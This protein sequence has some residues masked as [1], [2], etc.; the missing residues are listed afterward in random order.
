MRH[1]LRYGL[2]F[3]FYILTHLALYAFSVDSAGTIYAA[4]GAQ[5]TS[6]MYSLLNGDGLLD[7]NRDPYS[8]GTPLYPILLALL[9]IISYGNFDLYY[10]VFQSTVLFFTGLIVNNAF[11]S[12]IRER[13][14]F[15][16]FLIIFSPNLYITAHFTQT[17]TIYGILFVSSFF[18]FFC[19]LV[20]RID[21]TR[22]LKKLM[23]S[24]VLLALA[25]LTRPAA[26]FFFYLF[27]AILAV[28]VFY[29][30]RPKIKD[31]LKLVLLPVCCY[32]M[33]I[34]PWVARN[35][36][37]F[38]E[39]MISANRGA[40]IKDQ[41][42]RL[43]Q[44]HYGINTYQAVSIVETKRDEYFHQRGLIF[45]KERERMPSCGDA[46]ADSAWGI[47]KEIPFASHF[48]AGAVSIGTLFLSAG[49]ANYINYL[50]YDGR[51]VTKRIM[52]NSSGL[53]QFIDYFLGSNKGAHFY[54]LIIGL[55]I[56]VLQLSLAIIGGGVFLLERRY[57]SVLSIVAVIAL[58]VTIYG[59]LGNSRF[60]VPL[61]PFFAF[62]GGMGLFYLRSI[63]R[64]RRAVMHERTKR[65]Q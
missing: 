39:L 51:G 1:G 48:K 46:L 7:S 44:I 6:V 20:E 8:F 11:N 15:V 55:S 30:Y 16:F 19:S 2:A 17:E 35:Y 56:V 45:C 12:I 10:M 64:V 14:Y 58:Y 21:K 42:I 62:F 32:L 52:S 63:Y 31:V 5:Y 37:V 54:F 9:H 3:P 49:S 50:G 4:D 61:E 36:L 57:Y 34:S 18:L 65:C 59:Y 26:Q 22:L 41:A 25:T 40:Y 47:I 29:L 13:Q 60:R 23:A 38:D 28:R 27:V 33:V 43:T 53:S 24:F